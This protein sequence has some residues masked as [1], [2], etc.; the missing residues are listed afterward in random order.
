MLRN[1]NTYTC[2]LMSY[3]NKFDWE[4]CAEYY[5]EIYTAL[6]PHKSNM[7]QIK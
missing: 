1:T 7:Y 2:K 6:Q 3:I 4:D 5:N